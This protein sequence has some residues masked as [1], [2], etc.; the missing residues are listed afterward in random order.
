MPNCSQPHIRQL[1]LKSTFLLVS[2]F[3][4]ATLLSQRKSAVLSGKV[5]DEDDKP[6]SRVSVVILGRQNGAITTD[7]GT[8]TLR[9]PADKA[10]AVVFSYTGYKTQQKNFLLNENEREYAVV[11]LEHARGELEAVTVTD[12]RQRTE[13]GL[14]T[15]NPRNAINI[16]SPTGGIESLIKVFVGTN[17]ELTSQYSVRG[18]NYDEN[19]IYVNDFE[20]FRPY[21]VRSGQQEGLSFINPELVR[22]VNFYNGGFQAKYGDKMSSV[23]DIQYKK[24]KKFGG[25]GYA[26]LLEQGFHLEGVSK[27]NKFTYLAGVRNRSNRN[28]L[29]SQETKGNYVPSSSDIQALLTY[30]FHD[31]SSLELLANYSGTKFSLEP[32]FSQLT[33]SV[34]S[35]FF[36]ANLGLDIYFAGRERDRYK[37]TMVGLS[38]SHQLNPKLRLKWMLSR[39]SNDEKEGID[40]TGAYLFGEREFDKS[41]SDFGLITNPLGAGLYQTFARNKLNINVWNASHKGS[42]DH[43][44]HYIQW[45]QS[46]ERQSISDKLHE[47][48]YLDSAG[49]NL[50]YN[51]SSLVLNQFTSSGADINIIRLSGYLQDNFVINE[52]GGLTMQGGARYNYNDLNN[53]LL[54]SPRIGISWKPASWVRD[55]IFRGSAGAYHQP[56]FYRELRRPDGRINRDLKAQRSYQAVAGFDYNFRSGSRPYRLTTEAYYKRMSRVVPYDLD[57]VRLRY[58]GNNEAKAYAAGLEVRLFSELVKDAESWISV[59][60]MRTR[61]NLDNDTYYNYTLDSLNNVT[62]SSLQQGGWFRRPADR[63]FTFGMFLQDYLATNKNFKVYLN[64]LYGSNMPYNIP[65]SIKYRNALTIDPYIRIDIGFSALLLDSDKANRRSHNPFRNFEN[66]WATFEV[67]NLI[68]R[69]NTISYMLIKDFSNTRYALPNRLTPRLLNL[70]VIARF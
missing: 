17:N 41:K 16:P 51:P 29:G 19:L 33:S 40:I 69:D 27:N 53:E 6:L 48:E 12:Q 24:P 18:G 14:I 43:G 59:G 5:V 68:D 20:V 11:K 52:S 67:F 63:L 8:F 21:L 70:K 62:D 34:F 39:F 3:I 35:P 10:F 13:A 2:L 38:Y 9:T 30:Q 22:N 65:G 42:L 50:P 31:R 46:V 44:K 23:L 45:G 55:I 32:Q 58:T 60:F 47:W 37:T 28:L 26:G 54:I 57:N 66:I 49:Y 25:S 56:P 15:V 1:L 61:E 36:S 64:F 7:S 4:F